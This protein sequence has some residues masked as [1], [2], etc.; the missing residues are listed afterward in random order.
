M[1]DR[2]R[3]T[4]F[5]SYLLCTKLKEGVMLLNLESTM[6]SLPDVDC[7]WKKSGRCVC[8]ATDSLN[9]LA[10]ASITVSIL[11]TPFT[12]QTKNLANLKSTNL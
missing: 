8:P 12:E 6:T 2:C 11:I 9:S 7:K 10:C 5:I 3:Y 1:I 4:S